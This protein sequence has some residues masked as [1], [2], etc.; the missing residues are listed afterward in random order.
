MDKKPEFRDVRFMSAAEKG[1]VLE[2]WE[3]FLQNGLESRYF[4]KR[5]YE[6]L[7]QHCSFIAHYNRGGFYGQYF[8]EIRNT[9]GFINQFTD[10]ITVEYGRTGWLD[11]DYADV[12]RAMCEVMKEYGPGLKST[13]EKA[14]EVEDIQIALE[15]LSRHGKKCRIEDGDH[16]V[17]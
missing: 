1:G 7:I 11:G 10:G 16:D 9:G 13:L 8:E 6:H 15:L 4:T 17:Q 5:L 12:N 2:D 3:A 14:I